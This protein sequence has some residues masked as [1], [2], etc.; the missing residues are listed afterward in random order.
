MGIAVAFLRDGKKPASDLVLITP[1]AI[2]QANLDQAER[3][4]EKA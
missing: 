1:V 2:T 4:G 3:L